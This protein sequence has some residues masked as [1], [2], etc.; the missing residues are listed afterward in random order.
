MLAGLPLESLHVRIF[1][2]RTKPRTYPP[3]RRWEALIRMSVPAM[4]RAGWTATKTVR[5]SR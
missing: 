5:T 2:S 4:V 3:W 1:R